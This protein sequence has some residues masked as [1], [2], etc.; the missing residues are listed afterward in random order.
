MSSTPWLWPWAVSTTRRS[1][2]GDERLG[3]LEGVGADADGGGDPEPA[4]VVL[5]GGRVLGLLLDVLDGDEPAEGAGVVD[6][7]QLLDAVLPEDVLGLLERGAER[8]GDERGRLHHPLDRLVVVL[9]EAQVAVG[10]DADELPAT[11]DDRDA[12][13]LVAGHQVEGGGHRGVGRQRDGV[14]DHPALRAL[15]PVD[16]EHLVLDRQVA[17]HRCRC[18]RGGPWRWRAGLR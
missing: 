5:G 7:R 14:G 4:P 16:L 9:D 2:P 12:R 13:D 10:E 11:V 8:R 17:V 15:H 3:P 6:D 1:T 18:R